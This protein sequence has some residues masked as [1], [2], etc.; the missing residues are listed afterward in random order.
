MSTYNIV[1]STE[2]ATVVAVYNAE[3]N[4]RPESYQSEAD[5]E[6]EFISILTTQGYEYL[7]IHNAA[8][9]VFNLRK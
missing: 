7:T 3:H 5:L 6:R 9:L 8:V 4:T 1:A 2:E